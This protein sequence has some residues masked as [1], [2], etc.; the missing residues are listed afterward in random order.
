MVADFIYSP[1]WS[2]AYL[3][4]AIGLLPRAYYSRHEC[5]QKLTLLAIGC[6]IVTHVAIQ[7]GY[8]QIAYLVM[9]VLCMI[10]C[11]KLH[12]RVKDEASAYCAYIAA[13]SALWH[14]VGYHL[15]VHQIA[16]NALFVAQ[17]AVLFRFGKKYGDLARQD[18]V[19]RNDP[20]H[21]FVVTLRRWVWMT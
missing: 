15:A 12:S 10:Y 19:E 20:L 5:I 13:A 17:L 9:D 1:L 2:L 11:L 18:D 7:E 14:I 3:A 6:N 16:Y 4:A 21:R 8:A